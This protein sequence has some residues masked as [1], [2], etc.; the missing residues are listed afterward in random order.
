MRKRFVK[1]LIFAAIF[2]WLIKGVNP[3]ALLDALKNLKP[4]G[5]V[6]ALLAVFFS[7]LMISFRWYYL[8]GFKHSFVSS[9]EANMLAFFLNIFAPAKLG[10]LAKIYYM[11]KKDSH[12]PKHSSSIFL[13]ERF[14][15]VIILAIII[16]F[17]A[18]F[19]I[20]NRSALFV[21][22]TLFGLV[23][24]FLFIVFHRSS[25]HLLLRIIKIKKLKRTIF[26]IAKAMQTNLTPKR[27]ATTFLLSLAVWASY[28]LNNFIFFIFATN[29]HLSLQQIFIAST[30]AFAVSAIPL[31]PG[32]IGTFQAAFIITLGWYGIGKEEALGVSTILQILYILPATLYSAYL[33]LTKDFLWEKRSVSA[34][35]L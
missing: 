11:H 19:I 31:T 22:L 35:N 16:A 32:G 8:S 2:Y 20:P 30:L 6:L 15:D 1:F 3:D 24:T 27:V 7:D 4:S 14:F 18:L 33:F 26:S 12:D 10:D 28:Y 29:F 21:S 34:K 25:L 13:I 17:A 5:I 9:L 23:I